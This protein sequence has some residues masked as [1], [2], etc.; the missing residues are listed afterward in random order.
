MKIAKSELEH[1]REEVK[2]C[3]QI[4]KD[5]QKKREWAGLTDEEVAYFSYVLD[6]WTTTHIRAIEA[7]LKAKNEL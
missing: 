6:H 1:L 5:L 7:L 2:N 3:H 4:I